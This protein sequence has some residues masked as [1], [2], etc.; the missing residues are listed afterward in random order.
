MDDAVKKYLASIGRKGGKS[1]TGKAKARPSAVAS[2]AGKL[3]GRPRLH[4]V[5]PRY[6]NHSFRNGRCP[7]GF[8]RR[9]E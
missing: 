7:C 8:M 9:K 3:G 4:G 6:R 5:C 2:R 1:G